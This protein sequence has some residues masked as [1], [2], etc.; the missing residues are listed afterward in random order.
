ME[1]IVDFHGRAPNN[2]EKE[3]ALAELEDIE[4]LM[5]EKDEQS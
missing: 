1:H 3:I 5:G 4:K 2:K